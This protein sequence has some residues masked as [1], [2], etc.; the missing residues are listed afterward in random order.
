MKELLLA[1]KE[2]S[3]EL[4][5]YISNVKYVAYVFIAFAIVG[6]AMYY[7]RKNDIKNLNGSTI[8]I[9]KDFVVKRAD[10]IF[11]IFGLCIA[12]AFIV[13]ISSVFVMAFKTGQIEEESKMGLTIFMVVFFGIFYLAIFIGIIGK[14]RTRM[15]LTRGEFCIF[16][17][18]VGDKDV[19][20]ANNRSYY[21]LYL[22]KYYMLTKKRIKVSM[23]TYRNTNVNDKCYVVY[24]PK[25]KDRYVFNQKHFS[26][27]YDVQNKVIDVNDISNYDSKVK[28]T[29][30]DLQNNIPNINNTMSAED[31]LKDISKYYTS[32]VA[33]FC[34]IGAILLVVGMAFLFKFQILPGICLGGFGFLCIFAASTNIKKASEAKKNFINGTYYIVPAVVF[35]DVSEMHLKDADKRKYLLTDKFSKMI[36]LPIDKFS[37]ITTGSPLLLMFAHNNPNEILYALNTAYTYSFDIESK[38]N[39]HFLGD[40]DYSNV[41]IDNMTPMDALNNLKRR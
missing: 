9:S 30:K 15:A 41:D 31:V 40:V 17:D 20:H 10:T 21:Y 28:K 12:L 32:G 33:L 1:A 11:D 6:I 34:V 25:T 36:V 4:Q 23:Q 13:I 27:D 35:R 8:K 7:K 37:N 16:E 19:R 26:L 24:I 2:L 29:Y 14:I 38:M 5:E 3:P 22:K 18:E 39:P